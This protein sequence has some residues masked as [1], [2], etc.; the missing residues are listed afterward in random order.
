M[1]QLV[2]RSLLLQHRALLGWNSQLADGSE[3]LLKECITLGEHGL[4]KLHSD[5]LAELLS[6]QGDIVVRTVVNLGIV[7]DQVNV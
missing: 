2:Y 5:Q 4:L 6:I 1:P 7:A 3:L